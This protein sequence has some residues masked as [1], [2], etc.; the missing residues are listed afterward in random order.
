[1]RK[2]SISNVAISDGNKKV[3]IVGSGIS[4]CVT[5]NSLAGFGYSVSLFEAGRGAGGRASTRRH[6]DYIFDHG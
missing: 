1:M 3:A 6:E 2:C 5:A 4:S